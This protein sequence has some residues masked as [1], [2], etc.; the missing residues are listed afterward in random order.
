MSTPSTFSRR[1]ILFPQDKGGI[2]K[3]FV[4]TLLYDF[5]TEHEVRLKTF[6][7]DSA[8]STFKRYV[9]AAEFI[10]TD[11]DANKL[12]VLDQLFN[13][14]AE[15]DT[16]LADNRAAGGAKIL[17][18]IEDSRLTQLQADIQ[19]AFIFVVIAVDDKDANSQIAE[20][21][22]RY[23]DRVRWLVVRN[24]RD[25]ATLSL[26][27]QSKSRAR[28]LELGAIEVDLPCLVE[29]TRN[30]LQLANLTVGMGRESDKLPLLDRSRCVQFH[31]RVG[32]EFSKARD[33]LLK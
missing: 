1:L 33:L 12:G 16:V 28:L 22:E 19:F 20:I 7:L 18:Y 5:L 8:N 24:Y 14:L 10:N 17:R 15:V 26:F 4:A 6:D 31:E 11:V 29:V 27:D 2:G 25:G 21:V 13:E 32:R 9:P 30:R 23:G 3:S